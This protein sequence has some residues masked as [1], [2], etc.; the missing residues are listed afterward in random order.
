MTNG[1]SC[2]N[3]N[4]ADGNDGISG[5]SGN[6]TNEKRLYGDVCVKSSEHQAVLAIVARV[7]IVIKVLTIVRPVVL[8]TTRQQFWQ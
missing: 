3:T 1:N 8:T 5:N 2:S 6:S 4:S 7:A